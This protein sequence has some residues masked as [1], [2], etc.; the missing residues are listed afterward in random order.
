MYIRQLTEQEIPVALKLVWEVFLEFE[1]PEY[2]E[3]GVETFREF[4]EPT[5]IIDKVTLGELLFIGCLDDEEQIVGVLAIRA[6]HHICLLFVLKKYH[7][8]GIA[9]TLFETA[10]KLCIE[11]NTG[12]ITVNSSPYAVEIYRKL[13]FIVAGTELQQNGIRYTPMY[14]LLKSGCYH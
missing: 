9:R 4:I 12:K 1:A 7:R 14:C 10:K 2:S 8:Q 6:F 3:E 13:G 5:S 11:R